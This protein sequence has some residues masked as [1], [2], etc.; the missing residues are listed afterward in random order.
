MTD[1]TTTK[2]KTS[3]PRRT[4]SPEIRRAALMDSAEHLFLTKGVAATSVE[5]I[6]QGAQ[7][8]KGTFY[9]YFGSRDA[10]L[11]ALQE[12]F[13]LGF[14]KR[15]EQGLAACESDNWNQRLYTW[16]L[17]AVSELI[18]QVML[19]DVLFHDT[20]AAEGRQLVSDNPVIEQLVALLEAGQD[21]QAW[22]VNNPKAL[23]IMM[24]HSMHG[25]ADEAIAL[26]NTVDQEALAAVL[27]HTFSKV[28]V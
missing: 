1:K 14:C 15:V 13:I 10:M 28:L 17:T 27:T 9:L 4:R 12:R 2:T 8:A 6:T 22:Q 16:F 11:S 24:F 5:D 23:A 19:H 21:A 25:I 3:K 26:G 7:V 18:T 20:K